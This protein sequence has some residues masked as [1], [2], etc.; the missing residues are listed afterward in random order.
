MANFPEIH[1]P[2]SLSHKE[3][4]N[5]KTSTTSKVVLSIILKKSHQRKV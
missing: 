3:V 5:L 4:E 1:N 2:Q